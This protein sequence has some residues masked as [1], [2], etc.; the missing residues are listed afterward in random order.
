MEIRQM[1]RKI[2]QSALLAAALVLLL[3]APAWSQPLEAGGPGGAPFDFDCSAGEVVTD[4]RLF[5]GDLVD[6]FTVGCLGADARTDKGVAW[7]TKSPKFGGGGGKLT[8]ISCGRKGVVEGIKVV[9]RPIDGRPIVANIQLYCVDPLN[10]A[11]W[12]EWTKWRYQGAYLGEF[13]HKDLMCPS[14]IAG[15]GVVKGVYGGAGLWL[16][17][18]GVK[19]GIL[20]RE[21]KVQPPPPPPPPPDRRPENTND[22]GGPVF[23]N[24]C[25]TYAQ[26]A[27][28]QI[29]AARF[30]SCGLTGPRYVPDLA[31][32][33]NW[34]RT[35][36]RDWAKNEDAERA[37]EVG[38]CQARTEQMN[39]PQQNNRIR[40]RLKSF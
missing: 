31:Q 15:Y 10:N 39:A 38:A 9:T 36:P 29:Q 25:S 11:R 30:Y 14:S 17:R 23:Q 28:E 6:A 8:P 37:R 1:S 2:R 7:G 19:C 16:D 13:R 20:Q 12:M 40:G 26:T 5:Q 34:C 3:A 18:I 4:M 24:Y 22:S 27:M 33:E 21:V 35:V 32:H